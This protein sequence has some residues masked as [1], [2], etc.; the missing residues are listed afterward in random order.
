MKQLEN[1]NETNCHA[2]GPNVDEDNVNLKNG[3]MAAEKHVNYI[4]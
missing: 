4:Y 1:L 3:V 2:S